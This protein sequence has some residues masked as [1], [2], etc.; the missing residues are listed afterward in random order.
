MKMTNIS[1]DIRTKEQFE[2]WENQAKLKS[3]GVLMDRLIVF[4]ARKEFD[5][6]NPFNDWKGEEQG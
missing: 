3:R 5:P 4:A 6:N 2:K 1:V